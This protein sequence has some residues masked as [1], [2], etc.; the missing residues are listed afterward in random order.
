MGV[1]TFCCMTKQLSDPDPALILRHIHDG[2]VLLD[3]DG[4]IQYANP[5]FQKISG[6]SMEQ[7]R[8]KTL[9]EVFD[10]QTDQKI[11]PKNLPFHEGDSQV[12]F[13]VE[14]PMKDGTLGSYCFFA[15]VVQDDQGKAIG[16][17]EN[18]RDMN[19]LRSMILQLQEVNQ[20]IQ[21]EKDK[22][23][24]IVDSMADGIFTIDGDLRILSFSSKMEQLTGI[25][26]SDAL[27]RKCSEVLHGTKC[28]TDCPLRWSFDHGEH[29]ER[30][31]EILRLSPTKQLPVS[32]T[33]AFLNDEE[34]GE[35]T[36]IGV[37]RDNTEIERLRGALHEKYSY[38]NIIG[39]SPA[40]RRLF[41]VIETVAATDATVLLEGETGTGKDLVAQAIHH[42]SLRKDAPFVML[43]CAALN[44]NLLESELF[45]HV[46]GAFTGAISDHAGRFEQAAGG[47]LFLDEIGDTSA[48]LQSKLLRALQ[49]KTF[50]RVGDTRMRKADV[51][52]I[53][54]TNRDL[55]K[56][57]GEGKFREDLYFRLA[58]IPVQLPSLRSRKEDIP[59][60]VEHFI[61]KY[62]SK[63]F[64]GREDQFEG[65]SQR[66]LSLLL[67]YDWPGNVRELEHAI[68]YAMISTTTNRIERSFFPDPI[69]KLQ[70]LEDSTEPEPDSGRLSSATMELRR[71]LELHHWNV[72][73]TANTL[74]ISR[75]TLWRRMKKLGI[76]L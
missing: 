51:R 53:A 3:L 7:L 43:N 41:Q 23:E 73:I 1:A 34:N 4:K 28:E 49:E 13:N 18:F 39:R 59:L 60:L 36:M 62:R 48:A 27:G 12:H 70:P 6:F 71:Q 5:V 35:Q 46:K 30:C 72:T 58:V 52:I 25:V 40:M 54:A 67:H 42:S 56:L 66:A 50:E 69:R 17:L 38:R 19:R 61:E 8:S 11:N 47:T 37:V 33:T 76:S 74:G 65:I 31:R 22:T 24:K 68:E 32:I 21:Y 10:E 63:Y 75:T 44:D 16:L 9:N 57:V 29:V 15:S 64:H 2:L 20:A 45:G 26:A 55:K 14:L